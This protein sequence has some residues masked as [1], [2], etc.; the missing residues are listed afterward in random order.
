MHVSQETLEERRVGI[1]LRFAKKCI[2]HPKMKYL[3]ERNVNSRTRIGAKNNYKH[4]FIKPK[5][6]SVRAEKEAISFCIRLLNK[7]NI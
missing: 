7:Y 6:N 4:E 1:F 5:V 2:K 3:F